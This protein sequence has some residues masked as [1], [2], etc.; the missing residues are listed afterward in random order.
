MVGALIFIMTGVIAII[1]VA[2]ANVVDLMCSADWLGDV[3]VKYENITSI[4]LT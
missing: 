2:S 4:P 3:A 1:N